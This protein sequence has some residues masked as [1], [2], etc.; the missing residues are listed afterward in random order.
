M[1]WNSWSKDRAQ[2]IDA[3]GLNIHSSALP[4]II[5]KP[6]YLQD[7]VVLVMW[8]LN[9]CTTARTPPTPVL[10]C[11][12]LLLSVTASAG[13]CKVMMIGKRGHLFSVTCI[14]SDSFW[15]KHTALSRDCFFLWAECEQVGADVGGMWAAR[16][17]TLQKEDLC[18]KPHLR[19]RL[20][21]G[22]LQRV[23]LS[24]WMPL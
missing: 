19:L 18:A 16:C 12:T 1:K 20:F 21:K 10:G 5:Y 7:C 6:I 11:W 9:P 8:V 22:A 17:V 23:G 14:N 2:G 13:F 15:L 3:S 24:S 4:A